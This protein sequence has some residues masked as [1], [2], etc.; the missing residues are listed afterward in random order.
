MILI[1]QNIIKESLADQT[2]VSAYREE[3]TKARDK[4]P[5]LPIECLPRLFNQELGTHL[6]THFKSLYGVDAVL[7]L[8]YS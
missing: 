3:L 8:V 1:W 7:S 5:K 2:S 6:A 4:F